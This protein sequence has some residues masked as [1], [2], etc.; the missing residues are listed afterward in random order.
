MS[1]IESIYPLH[2]ANVERDP[3]FSRRLRRVKRSGQRS[4]SA[5][6]FF[7]SVLLE[8]RNE[9]FAPYGLRPFEWRSAGAG[10]I[11]VRTVVE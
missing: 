9:V 3:R 7:R 5:M 4:C 10:D 6:S 2:F 11:G 1:I 8:Q